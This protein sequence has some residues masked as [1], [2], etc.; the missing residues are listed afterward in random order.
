MFNSNHVHLL[1]RDTAEGVMGR[2]E[3]SGPIARRDDRW[4]EPIAVGSEGFVEQLKIELG[5]REQ[6]RQVALADG[7]YTLREPVPSSGDHFNSILRD[8]ADR[9]LAT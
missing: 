9:F 2:A 8:D 4:S 1:V 3:S 5:S 6:N 7:L